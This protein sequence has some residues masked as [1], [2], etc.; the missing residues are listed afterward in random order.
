MKSNRRKFIKNPETAIP[1][2][3]EVLQGAFAH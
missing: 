3:L 1:K 2:S